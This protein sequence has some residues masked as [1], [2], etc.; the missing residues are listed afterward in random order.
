[1]SPRDHLSRYPKARSTT[2]AHLIEQERVHAK[3]RAEIAKIERKRKLDR[4]KRVL[5]P[6]WVWR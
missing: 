6:S 4:I 5:W 1:V 3:L 2:L